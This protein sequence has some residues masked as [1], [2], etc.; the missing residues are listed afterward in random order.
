MT[1]S[2]AVLTWHSNIYMMYVYICIYI[3]ISKF[4]LCLWI[5]FNNIC[6][7]TSVL[8][9]LLRPSTS[10]AD[11]YVIYNYSKTSIFWNNVHFYM[12]E[13]CASVKFFNNECHARLS[14]ALYMI[15]WVSMEVIFET[16]LL[17]FCFHVQTVY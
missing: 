4:N 16:F 8:F 13:S 10:L 17:A 6:L 3:Y 9:T 12:Y 1:F 7:I 2:S 14:I 15:Q 11:D 5:F